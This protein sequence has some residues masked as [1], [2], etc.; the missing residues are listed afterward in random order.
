MTFP[1]ICVQG[2]TERSEVSA[3]AKQLD[4]SRADEE[5]RAAHRLVLGINI[6]AEDPNP[7]P[8]RHL[9]HNAIKMILCDTCDVTQ[10]DVCL[11]VASD[12]PPAMGYVAMGIMEA[13]TPSLLQINDHSPNLDPLVDECR[14]DIILRIGPETLP[15]LQGEPKRIAAYAETYS[16]CTY[17]RIMLD[18]SAGRGIPLDVDFTLACL[19]AIRE[20]IPDVELGISGG[21]D[22]ETLPRILPIIREFP[23]VSISAEGRLRTPDDKLDVV[24]AVA[25][26]EKAYE[27]FDSVL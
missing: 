26:I 23:H 1:Y 7:P 22:A 19:E 20:A 8:A 24:K 14:D 5:S 2:V 12:N 4:S 18:A 3:L 17:L 16:A 25:F 6:K 13:F 10:V 9:A 27:L 11:H 15:C 21:L